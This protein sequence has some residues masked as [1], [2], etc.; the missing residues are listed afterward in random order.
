MTWAPGS[1]APQPGAASRSAMLSAQTRAELSLI[2]RNSEQVLL[3]LVIPLVLL[4]LL[5]KVSIVDV[6]GRRVDFFV[7]GIMA[8]AVMSSSFTGQAIATGFDREYGVLKRLGATPLPRSVLLAAK[9][10]ATLTVLFGQLVVIAAVGLTLGW[11]PHGDPLSLLAVLALGTAAFSGLGLLLGGTLRGL[12]SLAV[13]NVLWFAL[14]LAGGILFPL[15]RYGGGED[16]LRLL[17]SASLSV[18]LRS[19]LIDADL[20]GRDLLVLAVWAAASLA[21]AA[22]AFR[23]D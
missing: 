20:P 21:A 22:R 5:T 6:P 3:N 8:L 16:L 1:L 14:L 17:P 11:H 12:Q 9:T 13:A 10:I 7:P 23:W 19:V 18:G 2:V 15:T 4:V